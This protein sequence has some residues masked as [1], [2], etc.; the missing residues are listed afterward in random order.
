MDLGL[1]GKVALVMAASQGLGRAVATELAREGANVVISSRDE[2][3]L[4]QTAAE[5]ADETGAE[6]EPYAADITRAG[7]IRALFSH[8]AQRFGGLD[9]LVN[10]AG[11]PPAGTFEDFGDEDWQAAFELVLLSLIRAIREALPLMRERREPG[12]RIVNIA[13][14]SIKQ[15][16]ENLIFSN[17]F[18]AGI[19][20]LAKSLSVELAPD[21]ILINTLGPGRIATARSQSMD[22]SQA[23]ARGVPIEEVRGEFEARI[24]LGRYGEP[25][26]LAKVAAF[27]ASPANSY[28][29][30]QAILV[31]GGMVRAL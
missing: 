14:S 19:L 7:D 15:P 10:N 4:S 22:A 18:R 16:I 29:T 2:T 5:I 30:G 28:V 11:G 8:A 17:T 27:L 26:E 12:G 31:D 13:S 21:G 25:E 9:V 3:T 24:P 23:E 20:G 6:V 1:Q